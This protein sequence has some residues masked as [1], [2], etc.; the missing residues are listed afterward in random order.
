M[1]GKEEAFGGANE[2]RIANIKMYDLWWRDESESAASTTLTGGKLY[3]DSDGAN[4]AAVVQELSTPSTS[5]IH[6]LKVSVFH[7]PINVDI[8][9][10]LGG[11]ELVREEKLGTGAHYL[12]FTPGVA[13]VYVKMWHNDNAGRIVDSCQIVTGT[14]RLLV[15]HPYLEADLPYLHIQQIGDVLYITNGTYWTRKLV[16]RGHRSWSVERFLPS[17][18]PFGTTNAGPM[19]LTP[20]A[21]SGQITLTSSE[22]YFDATDDARQPS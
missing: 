14:T 21:T 10:S 8:G 1:T 4:D 2:Y 11:H 20:S 13:T 9:T 18:G 22:D 5:L 12:A 17:D 7:G 15:E 16:R 6:V 3:L 19:S